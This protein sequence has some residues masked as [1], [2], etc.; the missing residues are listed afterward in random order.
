[1]INL[2]WRI[3]DLGT[4]GV[5]LYGHSVLDIVGGGDLG[6]VTSSVGMIDIR[7]QNT[8]SPRVGSVFNV[9]IKDHYSRVVGINISGKLGQHIDLSGSESNEFT[10]DVTASGNS[11]LL[12]YKSRGATAIRGNINLNNGGFVFVALSNQISDSSVVRLSGKEKVS[13]FGFSSYQSSDI[14]ESFAKLIVEADAVLTFGDKY[15]IHRGHGQ[16]HLF[17]DDLE[18]TEG[19]SL[20][21]REWSEGRDHLLVRRDSEHLA[22]SLKRLHFEGYDPN[23]IHLEDYDKDYWE[24]NGAPEPATYGACSILAAL[25][26]IRYRKHRRG[27]WRGRGLAAQGALSGNC[28]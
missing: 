9:S 20:F 1:V 5:N 4:E 25:G 14:S 23:A 26:L 18:I 8:F 6:Y 27:R 10:G 15:D 22:E 3:L 12:L 13:I 16:R 7:F 28:L 24:I 11:G 21:V 2:N 17:L 19:S